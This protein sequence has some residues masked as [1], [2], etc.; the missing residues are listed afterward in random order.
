MNSENV[1]HCFTFSEDRTQL[2]K[3]NHKVTQSKRVH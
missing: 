3:E 2:V 1:T